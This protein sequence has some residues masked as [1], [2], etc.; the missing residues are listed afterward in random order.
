MAKRNRATSAVAPSWT[1]Q[2]GFAAALG[3]NPGT[4]SRWKH[5]PDWPVS[6][7]PPWTEADRRTVERWRAEALQEDRATEAPAP[8]GSGNYLRAKAVKT[9]HEARRAKVLADE[10]EQDIVTT[11]TVERALAAL[12]SM[13]VRAVDDLGERLRDELLAD[14]ATLDEVVGPQIEQLRS[15]IAEQAAHQIERIEQQVAEARGP[16]QKQ[17]GRRSA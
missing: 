7:R 14:P 6:N 5:R 11:E 12:A 16:R 9:Y 13:F 8:G 17:R 2:R 4:L 10:A 3:V 1:N 15:R